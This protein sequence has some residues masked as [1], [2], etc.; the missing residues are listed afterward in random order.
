MGKIILYSGNG[1]QGDVIDVIEVSHDMDSFRRMPTKNN[2]V[3]SLALENVENGIWIELHDSP[4]GSAYN[5]CVV[6]VRKPH[7]KYVLETFEKSIDDE[8]VQVSYRPHIYKWPRIFG[9]LD[10]RV[11][12]VVVM[13]E[14]SLF[15]Y[16][17]RIPL[18]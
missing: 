2:T 14:K 4:E 16:I 3:K 15:D 12:L 6:I 7:P 9:G 5:A 13:T 10:G 8:F 17:S 11:S 18:T 1:G